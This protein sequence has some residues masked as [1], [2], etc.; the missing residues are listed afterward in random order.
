MHDDQLIH[1]T[2][3]SYL[4]RISV[5]IINRVREADLRDQ[6]LYLKRSSCCSK[7]EDESIVFR[8]FSSY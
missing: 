4:A 6:N 7:R 1:S 5:P 2:T 8:S 3:E